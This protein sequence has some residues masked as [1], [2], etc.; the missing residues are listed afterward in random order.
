MDELREYDLEGNIVWTLDVSD[1][2]GPWV[3]P[4]EDRFMNQYDI[5]H[6]NTVF[7]D[8]DEDMIYY[9]PRNLNTFY[10][11][12]HATGEVLWGLGEYGDFT[13]IDRFGRVTDTLFYHGHALEKVDDNT[14]IIFDNDLHNQSDLYNHQTRMVEITVDE[15]TM[16]AYE[17]WTWTGDETYW[18]HF[19]GDA[20][21]LPN[22]NRLGVFGAPNHDGGNYGARI[23]EVNNEG[24]I[25]WEMN[26][27]ASDTYKW[28]I[29]RC[30]RIRFEPTLISP[31]DNLALFNEDVELTWQALYDFRSK[32]S[33]PGNY[34]AY[35]NGDLVST[36]NI[37]YD[38]FWRPVDVN[39]AIGQWSPGTYNVTLVASDDG[40]YTT[41]DTI[42]LNVVPVYLNRVGS[43]HLEEGQNE[44]VV[45][46]VGD[47]IH[48][49]ECV[50]FVDDIESSS[51]VW[52]GEDISLDLGVIDTGEH[53]I[54]L[55][56]INNSELIYTDEFTLKICPNI[57]PVVTYTPLI[58]SFAYNREAAI[59]W[60]VNEC[61]PAFWEIYVDNTLKVNSTW[62]VG[63]N[64]IS[65][66]PENFEIGTYNVTLVLVDM[67][68]HHVSDTVLLFITTPTPPIII[69]SPEVD[70]VLWGTADVSLSWEI[71]GGSYWTVKRNGLQIYGGP[72]T[73]TTIGF[74]IENWAG[75]MWT[76]GDNELTLEVIDTLGT[77]SDTFKVTV[78]QDPGDAYVDAI[79]TSQS[80]WYSNGINVIGAPDGL[81]A[82]IFQDYGPGY[83]TLDFGLNEEVVDE[84]GV[85]FIIHASGGNYSLSIFESLGST[86]YAMGV[87]NGTQ[88][89]DLSSTGIAVVRYIRITLYSD[90]VIELDAVEAIN[91][92]SHP[93]DNIPPLISEES[94]TSLNP[95]Q[96]SITLEWTGS[97]EN[98]M[99]YYVLHNGTTVKFGA[100]TGGDIEYL[101]TPKRVGLWNVTMVFSDAFGNTASDTVFVQVTTIPSDSIDITVLLLVSGASLSVAF[102]VV[103][104]WYRKRTS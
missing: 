11:I 52:S 3:C 7:Y 17:S 30:E 53:Q 103:A 16:T 33:M 47:T 70:S 91:Y 48:P 77:I 18:C 5:T 90:D 22:G 41:S 100:W 73:D 36:G 43:T 63:T 80:N 55:N 35:V 45:K 12:D 59:T 27:V 2:I 28:G 14:Y 82:S 20:D 96:N 50:I 83:M 51:F 78:M 8:D 1:F 34:S 88:S 25:V 85:D 19:W 99:S 84:V 40:G 4:Y 31:T 102:I 49:L 97:D 60:H 46:W 15:E 93:T 21:R 94:D 64:T 32:A 24:Q 98:P 61:A 66:I 26:F 38:R 58:K 54:E 75:E 57:L 95:T 81:F 68:N 79:V 62:T 67:A 39:V 92:N 13:L 74:T 71:R 65:W 86:P 72:V 23:T 104:I 76:I 69:S 87:F 44:Y 6:S 89:I 29:Y 42:W 37:T 56:L 101:F 10:K 9:H